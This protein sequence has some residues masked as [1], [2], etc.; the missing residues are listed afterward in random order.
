MAAMQS[1]PRSAAWLLLVS[2]L[3]SDCAKVAASDPA[4]T[5]HGDGGDVYGLVPRD[6]ATPTATPPPHDAAMRPRDL[7]VMAAHDLA[8]VH[9]LAVAHDLALP[10]PDLMHADLGGVF[11]P[12]AFYQISS[13]ATR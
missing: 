3:C 7:T 5:A 1:T 2:A 10:P 8:V 4:V 12:G 13:K 9:D 11:P 6:L